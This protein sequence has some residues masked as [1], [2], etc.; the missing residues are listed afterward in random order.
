MMKA[1]PLLA[2]E[3][4]ELFVDNKDSR[5]DILLAELTNRKA[6]EESKFHS[7]INQTLVREKKGLFSSQ[8]TINVSSLDPQLL[9]N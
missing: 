5:R 7:Y 1:S 3:V 4:K 6:K 8:E 9:I 2:S